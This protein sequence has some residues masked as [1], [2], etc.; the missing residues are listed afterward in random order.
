MY[1][2]ILTFPIGF[3][4]TGL[5]HRSPSKLERNLNT[6]YVGE[7]KW[8]YKTESLLKFQLHQPLKIQLWVDLTK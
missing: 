8:F 7:I 6:V 3:N 1:F 4:C 2:L 5:I